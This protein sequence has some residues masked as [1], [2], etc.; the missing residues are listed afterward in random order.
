MDRMSIWP[1]RWRRWGERRLGNDVCDAAS[2]NSFIIHNYAYKWLLEYWKHLKHMKASNSLFLS[3]SSVSIPLLDSEV[4][5][6]IIETPGGSIYLVRNESASIYNT[7]FHFAKVRIS[8]IKHH[9]RRKCYRTRS[10]VIAASR[11]AGADVIGLEPVQVVFQG[12]LFSTFTSKV[13]LFY[14]YLIMDVSLYVYDLSKVSFP[15]RY[16]VNTN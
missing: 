5:Q 9:I 2:F 10:K 8:N 6:R 11:G 14:T 4:A 3:W 7:T 1:W 12:L 16:A 13:T 15:V